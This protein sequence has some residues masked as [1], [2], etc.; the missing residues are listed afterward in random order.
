MIKL[1]TSQFC[2]IARNKDWQLWLKDIDQDLYD[3][4]NKTIGN[5]GCRSVM[6]IMIDIYKSL[7]DNG[8]GK[9]LEDFV[10]RRFPYIIDNVPH[11]FKSKKS[12]NTE[13]VV[14]KCYKPHILTFPHKL[15]LEGENLE[16]RVRDFL[17]DKI[18]YDYI[19]VDNKAYIEYFNSQYKNVA[20]KIPPEQREI[21]CYR[22]ANLEKKNG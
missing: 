15:I 12:L 14:F 9:K 1:K 22:M 21:H 7:Y 3:Q 20:I 4:L 13:S 16:Q 10:N 19:I 2:G 17:Y 6:K 18:D 8:H 5:N 11:T